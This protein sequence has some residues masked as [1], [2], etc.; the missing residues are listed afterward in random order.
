MQRSSSGSGR[1]VL[2]MDDFESRRRNLE[3]EHD[4]LAELYARHA[5]SVARFFA[6]RRFSQDDVQDLVQETFLSAFRALPTLRS[7][8]KFEAW[9]F[10]IATNK[11]RNACRDRATARGHVQDLAADEPL[12]AREDPVSAADRQRSDDPLRKALVEEEHRVLREALARLSPPLRNTV[13]LRLDQGLSYQEIATVL[14]VPLGTV[15]SRLNKAV[16][17]LQDALGET[18]GK[19][20][21]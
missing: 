18:Y 19:V 3:Q 4:H 5:P 1:L 21:L 13:L 8:E 15:Q 7:Q 11:W 16:R 10:K 12:E 2:R 20:S 14:R 9:L 6:N 17:Q